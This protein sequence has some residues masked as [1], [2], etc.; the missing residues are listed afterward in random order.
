MTLTMDIQ[1]IF[2]HIIVF[3]VGFNL[4]KPIV[5]E[6]IKNVFFR[7]S[8]RKSNAGSSETFLQSFD[9]S[10]KNCNVKH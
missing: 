9:K 4:I 5:F 6:L 2:V 8:P 1:N 3:I 7:K 10:C